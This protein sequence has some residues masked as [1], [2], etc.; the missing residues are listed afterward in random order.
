[1]V[2]D[3]SNNL[4]KK[5]KLSDKKPKKKLNTDT[6]SNTNTSSLIKRLFGYHRFVE[7]IVVLSIILFGIIL[8]YHLI[9]FRNVDRITS[10]EFYD[11]NESVKFTNG[12]KIDIQYVPGGEDKITFLLAFE[13]LNKSKSANFSIAYEG[14]L[15]RTEFP[16]NAYLNVKETGLNVI[17][18]LT[19]RNYE[20]DFTKADKPVLLD[21]F[22]GKFFDDNGG[23][24]KFDLS[25]IQY[26]GTKNE[27]NV[28]VTD[29]EDLEIG[30]V[31]PKPVDQDSGYTAF[32]YKI[33][34]A[35]KIGGLTGFWFNQ[36]ITSKISIRGYNPDIGNERKETEFL[37][38]VVIAIITSAIVSFII[39]VLK[40]SPRYKR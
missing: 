25:L 18:G 24:V 1:M 39:D 21:T 6:R 13:N 34:L 8:T 36:D 33:M 17:D 30:S 7:I 20:L 19:Y 15:E 5:I 28:V 14:K 40:D 29:P 12:S 31:Y 35:Q 9:V 4:I 22:S 32:V 27:I 37:F 38:G 16:P 11:F 2:H 3:G 10:I 26:G 23:D